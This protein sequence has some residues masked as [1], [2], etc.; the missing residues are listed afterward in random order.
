MKVEEILY[1]LLIKCTSKTA[2]HIDDIGFY[3]KGCK[4]P[5]VVIPSIQT[6]GGYESFEETKEL[7]SKS[8]ILLPTDFTRSK[9]DWFKSDR[10]ILE[11]NFSNITKIRVCSED[12]DETLTLKEVMSL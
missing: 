2:K 4:H 11:E 5:F 8:L 10:D 3:I 7:L 9:Q 1:K 12:L 6:L